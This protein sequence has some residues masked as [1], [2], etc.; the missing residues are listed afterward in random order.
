MS[1]PVWLLGNYAARIV[2]NSRESCLCYLCMF[3]W[4]LAGAWLERVGRSVG[5]DHLYEKLVHVLFAS[6]PA[7]PP[8]FQ[9]QVHLNYLPTCT[10]DPG[11]PSLR[12]FIR[13][14][15]WDSVR[16]KAGLL[17]LANPGP[18]AA[19][20]VSTRGFQGFQGAQHA[21]PGGIEVIPVSPALP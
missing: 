10:D 7:A 18:V 2:S 6:A 19:V 20:A 3:S 15:D 21:R 8:T 13:P 14:T 9:S 16:S 17:V 1:A 11:M 12:N 4:C 5:T